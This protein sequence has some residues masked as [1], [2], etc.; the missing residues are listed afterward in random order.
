MGKEHTMHDL[1]L[2]S[3]L[4]LSGSV[5]I[6]SGSVDLSEFT[7]A[8]RGCRLYRSDGPHEILDGIVQIRCAGQDGMTDSRT[9]I[10]SCT[11]CDVYNKFN[12][13]Y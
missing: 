8:C 11:E 2:I 13:H 3:A 4:N 10:S 1:D 6:E 12:S 7:G 9:D 5:D